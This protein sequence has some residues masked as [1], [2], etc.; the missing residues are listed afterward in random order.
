M[1]EDY[2]SEILTY[3]ATTELFRHF[4]F[5][6]NNANDDC[7][8]I[9]ITLNPTG[10]NIKKYLKPLYSP[11]IINEETEFEDAVELCVKYGVISCQYKDKKI[12]Y[13]LYKRKAKLVFN[14]EFESAFRKMLNLEIS[15]YSEQWFES[16]NNSKIAD[17]KKEHL[18]KLKPI[19]YTG[20]SAKEII[21]RIELYLNDYRKNDFVREVS[22]YIFF[23]HSKMLDNRQDF[24][25][26]FE[27]EQAPIQILIH[28][29]SNS[30]KILFIENKQTF[31]SMKLKEKI[32][33]EYILVYLSGFMGTAMRLREKKYRAFYQSNTQ[34]HNIDLNSIF[35]NQNLYSYFFWG[36]FDYAGLGIFLS[37]K[38]T[39]DSL[40]FWDIGYKKMIDM[41]K[42]NLGHTKTILKKE[43]QNKP[44]L[45]ERDI[46]N[47]NYIEIMDEFGFYDQE[48]ILI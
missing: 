34:N 6:I 47:N 17:A 22:A 41:V 40:E 44:N 11:S 18:F 23:G 15:N 24:W 8:E 19:E 20:K 42:N 25:E 9:K 10:T 48:G 38:K 16:I 43:N 12:T 27:I 4:I 28:N 45:K 7:K 46:L 13:P 31:E 26:L 32:V 30:N 35:D 21:D 1:K 5:L 14:R 33:N 39:F 36:D 37:L 3:K 2:V 29:E